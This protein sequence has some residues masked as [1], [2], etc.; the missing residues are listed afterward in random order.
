M[1]CSKKEAWLSLW[2][3]VGPGE[4]RAA[5]SEQESGTPW[6]RDICIQ[7][8]GPEAWCGN[9]KIVQLDSAAEHIRVP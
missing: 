1:L 6:G 4:G 5:G 7:D 9:W 3:T 2:L 8:L